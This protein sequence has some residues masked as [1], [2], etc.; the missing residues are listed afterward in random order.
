MVQAYGHE[1]AISG[2]IQSA[3]AL[4]SAGVRRGQHARVVSSETPGVTAL[5]LVVIV[6]LFVAATYALNTLKLRMV[7]RARPVAA[8]ALEG[9]QGFMYVYVLIRVLEG[10]NTW[11]GIAAYVVGAFAGTLGAMLWQRRSAADI[12]GHYHACCPPVGPL[13][14]PPLVHASG[15]RA[16]H[17]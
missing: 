7:A 10:A 17:G 12:P 6:V 14:L 13:P 15:E 2:R 9:A 5:E 8:A 1:D 4:R 16:A 3:A 11:I